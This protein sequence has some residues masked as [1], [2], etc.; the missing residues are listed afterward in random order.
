M[1]E[2]NI[3]IYPLNNLKFK[4]IQLKKYIRFNIWR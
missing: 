2:V 4:K 3:Q 1:K